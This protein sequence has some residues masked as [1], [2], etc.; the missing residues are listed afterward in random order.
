MFCLDF[1]VHCWT[2]FWH[3]VFVNDI[4]FSVKELGFLTNLAHWVRVLDAVGSH[5]YILF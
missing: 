2:V 5:M 3:I 1:R 4:L